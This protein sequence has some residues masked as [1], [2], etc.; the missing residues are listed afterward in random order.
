MSERKIRIL[1]VDDDEVDRAAVKRYIE[2]NELPYE[3]RTASSK[4]EALERLREAASDVVLLD[5][6]LSDGTGLE[7]LA[8]LDETPTIVI[9]GHGS[10]QIA[11]DAIRRGACDYVIKDIETHYLT[12]LPVTIR[13]VLRRKR[14]EWELRENEAKLRHIYENSP[15]M[16]HSI[17]EEARIYNVNEKWLEEMG[18]TRDEVIGRKIDFLMTPES[19]QRAVREEIPRFWREGYARDVP[20]Q[21]VK[22][23]GTVIDVLVNCSATTD[24]SG[25]CISLSVVHDVTEQ[26]RAAEQVATSLK[27]KEVLLR[28]VHHRVK[29]NMQVVISLLRLQSRTIRS[30]PA[31]EALANS[32]NR[33]KAMALIH[34][35]LYQSENLSGITLRSYVHRLVRNLSSAHGPR[36]RSAQLVVDVGDAALDI[37]TAVP[38]GLIINELVSNSLKHAF[39]DRKPGEIRVAVHPAAEDEIELAVSDDGVGLPEEIDPRSA[40]T[41]GLRLVARLAEDQLGGKLEIGRAGGTCCTVRF[42]QKTS[43]AGAP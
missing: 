40:A 10:E 25:R 31:R 26:K 16:M 43:A 13:N 20:Y 9:T 41:L 3:L 27:E 2:K 17:D 1:L 5:Y 37:D 6:S 24:P 19:A 11:V 12:M 30:E 21:L 33:I 34:E 18:F 39:P 36:G 35:T 38:V 42:H 4:D 15:V 14:S 22:K 32:Q 23:D 8:Q 28:E 7:L 29:N